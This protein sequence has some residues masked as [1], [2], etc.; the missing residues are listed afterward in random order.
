[1]LEQAKMICVSDFTVT[2]FDSNKNST[3][4]TS[5]TGSPT[6]QNNSPRLNR[7]LYLKIYGLTVQN[8]N[9]T[10]TREYKMKVF[11]KKVP[12][13]IY[14]LK[15]ERSNRRVEKIYTEGLENLYCS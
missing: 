13:G 6:K 5:L 11:E 8:C 10:L 12:R 1:V 14:G 2:E 7:I 15:R 3:I 4:L 9:F